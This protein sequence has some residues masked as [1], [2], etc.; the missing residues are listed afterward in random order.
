MADAHG[1]QL[2]VAELLAHHQGPAETD[3]LAA[4]GL[5]QAQVLRPHAQ[6]HAL[7]GVGPET[8][9]PPL[10]QLDVDAIGRQAEAVGLGSHGHLE[11]VH[12]GRADEARDEAIERAPVEVERGADL[13]HQAVVHD[14]DAV[15]QRHGLDLVVGHEHRRGRHALA[16]LLDLEAHL[17][18]QLGVEI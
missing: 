3:V 2:L 15:A 9:E 10:R 12:G 13:L 4:V 14:D 8:R 17:R 5:P 18:A 1:Q 16:Q 6:R 7:A 11:E